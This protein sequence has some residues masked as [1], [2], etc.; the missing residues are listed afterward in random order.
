M[1]AYYE[2]L[3]VKWTVSKIKVCVNIFSE[4]LKRPLALI[5]YTS[6]LSSEV[7]SLPVG[8]D[9]AH[10]IPAEVYMSSGD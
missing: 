7:I 1:L 2:P 9:S 4:S 10:P 6:L 5:I 3:S 8:M